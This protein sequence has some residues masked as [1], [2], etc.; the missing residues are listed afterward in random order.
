MADAGAV[1]VSAIAIG[2]TVVAYQFFLPRMSDVRRASP[3]D[4]AM[5][6]DVIVGQLG[7]G[8]LSLAVGGLLAVLTRSATPVYASLFVAAV[9]AVVYHYAMNGSN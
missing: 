3:A 1:S 2:Q 8:A 9:I 5:Q 7:A 6:K 4:T